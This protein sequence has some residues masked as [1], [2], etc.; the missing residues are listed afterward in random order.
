M[1]KFPPWGDDPIFEWDDFN[2]SKIATKHHVQDFEI[3]QCF[4]NEHEIVPHP[5]A[6]SEPDKFGDRYYVRGVT[7]GGRKLLIVVQHMGEN[8][9]RP[10]TAW[11]E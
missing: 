5:K 7:S 4:E 10:V 6:T 8:L 11:A 1:L 9:V 2:A 3:E